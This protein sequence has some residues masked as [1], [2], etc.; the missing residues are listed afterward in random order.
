MPR[1][2]EFGAVGCALGAGALV[3][4]E[5]TILPHGAGAGR[6][7]YTGL[8]SIVGVEFETYQAAILN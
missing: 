5:I 6:A 4:H 7:A 1:D 3:W 8:S 2:F